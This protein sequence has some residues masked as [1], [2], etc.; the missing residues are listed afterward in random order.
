MVEENNNECEI[1]YINKRKVQVIY[2]EFLFR[3]CN[4]LNFHMLYGSNYPL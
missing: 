1:N 4:Y 2:F 3:L